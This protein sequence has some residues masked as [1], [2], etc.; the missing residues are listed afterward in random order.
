MYFNYQAAHKWNKERCPRFTGVKEH[1]NRFDL[2]IDR[3]TS[4]AIYNKFAGVGLDDTIS[5]FEDG[6]LCLMAL[7]YDDRREDYIETEDLTFSGKGRELIVNAIDDCL[8]K[9]PVSMP[10]MFGRYGLFS[11]EDI[12]KELQK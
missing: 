9:E 2:D 4:Q 12:I 5:I 3:E 11:V 8:A 1:G 6:T 7:E 10:A